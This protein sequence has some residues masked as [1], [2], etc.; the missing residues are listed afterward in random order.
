MAIL[1]CVN[2]RL[3]Q[4]GM[5]ELLR[6]F[7]MGEI[8]NPK[9]EILTTLATWAAAVRKMLSHRLEARPEV[10]ENEPSPA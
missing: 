3:T 8:R 6:P 7:R 9:L 10:V 1:G 4:S 2:P 5:A